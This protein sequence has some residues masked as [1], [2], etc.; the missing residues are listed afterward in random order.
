[1]SHTLYTKTD[2]INID[3]NK[4]EQ[5]S[6]KHSSTSQSFPIDTN[7]NKIGDFSRSNGLRMYPAYRRSFL[8]FIF[9][10]LRLGIL[11]E[12]FIDIAQSHP[13]L[14]PKR[15]GMV[16]CGVPFLFIILLLNLPV[17]VAGQQATI[18]EEPAVD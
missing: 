1:M 5:Q 4:Q 8:S 7:K 17:S 12:L 6:V 13:P 16:L 14:R 11:F 18:P 9:G 3:E 10:L 15:A 2:N